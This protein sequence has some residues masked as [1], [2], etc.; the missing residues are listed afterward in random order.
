MASIDPIPG[1]IQN[2][3]EDIPPGKPVVMLNLL[4]FRKEASYEDGRKGVSGREAYA[5]YSQQAIRSLRD[6]GGRL[7]WSGEVRA[8]LI[9][10]QNGEWHQVLLVR[11][12]SIEKFLEMIHSESY[13]T[14][15]FHRTAALEDSRLIATVEQSSEL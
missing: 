10:P 3:V 2:A 5:L 15:V 14:G 8:S 13:Q 9:G 4:K 1:Q 7:I 12:P 11:Y 6:I